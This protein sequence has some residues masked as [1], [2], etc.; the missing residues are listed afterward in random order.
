[1]RSEPPGATLTV[2]GKRMGKAPWTGEARTGAIIEVTAR[3]AGHLSTTRILR[4]TGDSMEAVVELSPLEVERPKQGTVAVSSTPWAYVSVD[5]RV[6]G[7]V[8]PV[9]LDLDPGEHTIVLENPEAGWTVERSVTVE[10]GKT[11]A[12]DVRK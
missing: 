7:Q 5:G 11:V 6:L 3:L 8:T 10:A 2:D 12:L 4:V 1:M 9:R